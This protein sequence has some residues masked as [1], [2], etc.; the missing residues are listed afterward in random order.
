MSR[1][2]AVGRIARRSRELPAQFMEVRNSTTPE[3][4]FGRSN[5]QSLVTFPV[6]LGWR[7]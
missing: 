4:I 7:V 3:F 6:M 5:V 1:G 2:G